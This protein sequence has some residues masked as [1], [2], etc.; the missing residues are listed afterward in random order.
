MFQIKK[1]HF[2]VD[3]IVPGGQTTLSPREALY[4]KYYI[5]YFNL[6]AELVFEDDY[7][8]SNTIMEMLDQTKG[9]KKLYSHQAEA[10]KHLSQGK[11]VVIS[12]S[13]ASGKS[14]IYQL[15]A[16]EQLNSNP[17]ATFCFIYPTKALAQD[18]RRAFMEFLST[19]HFIKRVNVMTFDGDTPSDERDY[20]KQNAN[21]I[22]TNPD[23]LHRTILP[24][25]EK[26]R[27][28][29]INLKLVVIDGEFLSEPPG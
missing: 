23:I 7:Q 24:C 3:Q 29:F 12:T 17:D 20:I 14:L 15:L 6:C 2:Y 11:N 9:I 13:T 19:T 21:I 22:I 5:L 4:G 26:W 28:F 1:E 16:L 10:I 18:Q 8:L 25:E 27:R